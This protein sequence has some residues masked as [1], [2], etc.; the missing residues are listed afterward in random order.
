MAKYG[1]DSYSD[2]ARNSRANYEQLGSLV[3]SIFSQIYEQRAAA[4]LATMFY[5]VNNP[6]Y[7]SKLKTGKDA[8]QLAQVAMSKIPE[9]AKLMEKQSQLAKTLS[10]GYMALTSTGDMYQTA[11]NGGYDKRTAGIAALMSAGGMYALM[12]NNRM[13]D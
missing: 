4:T 11:L 13:G 12:M 8:G 7:I 5:K 6:A 10:L 9:M 3:T 1:E 2:S